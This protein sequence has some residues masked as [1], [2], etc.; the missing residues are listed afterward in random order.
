MLTIE[1]HTMKI[2]NNSKASMSKKLFKYELW[3]SWSRGED[4]I[5][6][7]SRV[8][9]KAAE[10]GKRNLFL[11]LTSKNAEKIAQLM[12]E[13]PIFYKNEL[14]ALQEIF[15]EDDIAELI[16]KDFF[17]D[18]TAWIESQKNVVW[19]GEEEELPTGEHIGEIWFASY[20]ISKVKTFELKNKK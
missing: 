11:R 6:K 3:V 4:L 20:N 19:L 9:Q 17:K 2:K 8:V 18:P 10:R 5:R 16:P 1:K 15:L 12:Q 13:K 14:T 7:T